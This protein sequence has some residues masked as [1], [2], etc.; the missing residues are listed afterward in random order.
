MKRI[1]LFFSLIL[2]FSM[3]FAQQKIVTGRVT[4]DN[5]EPLPGAN[6]VVKGTFVGTITEADGN[7]KI[8][9]PEDRK[10]LSF[11][12]I[13]FVPQDINIDGKSTVNVKLVT[14]SIGLQ[15]VVA[16][17]YGVQK[18]ATMTGSVVSVNSRDLLKAPVASCS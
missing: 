2:S 10:V 18:K 11:S 15:E 17:G 9:I 12:F 4:D 6:V 3:L 5:N 16:V 1:I 13:G 8:Q 7:F 14:N